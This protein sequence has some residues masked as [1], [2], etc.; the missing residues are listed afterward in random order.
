MFS[1]SSTGK[2]VT[3][4]VRSVNGSGTPKEITV[5]TNS[6]ED[7]FKREFSTHSF[8]VPVAYGTPKGDKP[9]EGK[10]YKLTLEILDSND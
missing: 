1:V 2:I 8:S 5:F 3:A 4:R 6:D 9:F 10:R 7:G